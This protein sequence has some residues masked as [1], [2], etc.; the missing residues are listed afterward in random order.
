MHG[1]VS[2]RNVRR[3]LLMLPRGIR[4]MDER[5][6]LE[7]FVAPTE[8][9]QLRLLKSGMTKQGLPRGLPPL[10]SADIRG[11]VYVASGKERRF[12]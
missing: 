6:V 7:Y 2:P 3:E 9:F 5:L 1:F 8:P 10:V 12:G 11:P 4:A